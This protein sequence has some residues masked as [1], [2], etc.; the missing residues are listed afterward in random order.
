MKLL[1]NAFTP[2]MLSSLNGNIALEEISVEQAR[3]LAATGEY[4]SVVGHADTAAL[5]TEQLGVEV[6]FNRQTVKV[7]NGDELLL[8][9]YTGPRLP[10]G[11]TTL[12]E[13][14]KIT[15]CLVRVSLA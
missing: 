13:G 3:A 4:L 10:E 8:G 2:G 6:K 7:G 12:P 9:Q 5:F 14:A 11:A 15:W 1:V